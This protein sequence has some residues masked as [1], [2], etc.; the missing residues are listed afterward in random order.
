METPITKESLV[1]QQK[2]IVASL[3]LKVAGAIKH[4]V[5][6]RRE[7]ESLGFAIELLDRLSR[8]NADSYEPIG[9]RSY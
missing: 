9:L 5:Q 8:T 7:L 4:D 2:G 3:Q 6:Y 1:E